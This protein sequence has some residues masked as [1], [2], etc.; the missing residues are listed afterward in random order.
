MGKQVQF[1]REPVAVRQTLSDKLTRSRNSGKGHWGIA[2][3]RPF[4]S[5]PS[6][7]IRTAT[8]PLTQTTASAGAG[9]NIL[10]ENLV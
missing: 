8:T 9:E 5:L 10:K 6:R 1:L 3:R 4:A 7:N 2:L